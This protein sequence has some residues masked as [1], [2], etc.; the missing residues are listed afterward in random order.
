VC[1]YLPEAN[2]QAMR[3]FLSEI[4][5]KEPICD[6]CIA[7][8]WHNITGWKIDADENLNRDSAT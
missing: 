2:R 1:G 8:F 3:E 5:L 7:A 4:P 6:R